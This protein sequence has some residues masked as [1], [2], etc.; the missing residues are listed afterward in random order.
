[1]NCLVPSGPLLQFSGGEMFCPLAVYFSGISSP[2]RKAGLEINI[3]QNPPVIGR[4]IASLDSLVQ[5]VTSRASVSS[6]PYFIRPSI[7]VIEASY[8]QAAQKGRGSS[9]W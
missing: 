6:K 4:L 7:R 1:M 9:E 5:P 8:R 2:E 3:P